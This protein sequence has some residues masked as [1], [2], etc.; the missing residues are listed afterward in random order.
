MTD[1]TGITVVDGDLLAISDGGTEKRITAS[2]LKSYIGGYDG[3]I[4]TIDIDGGTDIGAALADADLFIVDDGAG[5][6]NRKLVCI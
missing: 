3:D 6:T 4:T 2:Q 5:G 1:G